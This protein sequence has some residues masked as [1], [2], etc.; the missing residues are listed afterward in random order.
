MSLAVLAPTPGRWSARL[1]GRMRT[2]FKPRQLYLAADA[3]SAQGEWRKEAESFE[4]WCVAHVGERCVVG[5]SSQCLLHAVVSGELGE[6]E[7][8]DQA[9]QQW[10]HYLDVDVAALEAHWLLR[11]VKVAGQ[12]LISAAPGREVSSPGCRRWGIAVCSL[13]MPPSLW[14]R[15]RQGSESWW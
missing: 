11:R 1:Q 7:A 15:C 6:Q 8:V 9:V 5:L 3:W 12:Y 4:A 10:A 2:L 13:T 14:R